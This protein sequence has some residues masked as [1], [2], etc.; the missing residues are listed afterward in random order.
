MFVY[1]VGTCL[2]KTFLMPTL[3]YQY[4]W[5]VYL[6]DSV[7]LVCM[8]V[9]LDISNS[10]ITYQDRTLVKTANVSSPMF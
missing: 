7:Y 8:I 4:N 9:E 1:G 3:E 2:Y 5:Q 6:N 10:M